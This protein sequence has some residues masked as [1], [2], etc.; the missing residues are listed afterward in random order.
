M[1]KEKKNEIEK[2]N[3]SRK[4]KCTRESFYT[5]LRYLL[6]LLSQKQE[7]DITLKLYT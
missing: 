2:P 6:L 7:P 4:D 1:Y 3:M 5:A